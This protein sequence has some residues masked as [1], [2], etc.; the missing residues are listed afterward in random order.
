[1]DP[2][3]DRALRGALA[4]IPRY[5]GTARSA[6]PLST[7]ALPAAIRAPPR[8]H[9][10]R[11]R[12]R[13]APSLVPHPRGHPRPRRRPG[14]DPR[15]RL[16]RRPGQ[17]ARPRGRP[18]PATS[19]N[20]RPARN[21]MSASSASEPEK[22][23][24]PSAEAIE[25][26]AMT[27]LHALA[28]RRARRRGRR[29]T[30]SSGAWSVDEPRGLLGAR[31]GTTSTSRPSG[32]HGPVLRRARDARAPAGS[33]APSS[34]T[35]STSSAART[36]TRSRSCHASELRELER[37]PTWGELREQVAA[38]AEGLRALGVERGDRVVAYLPNAPRGADRL[39][40]HRQPRRDLVELLAG[41]RPRQ[42]RR[43]L[44]P[45]RA[46]G[47]VRRRR[48][49]LRRQGLRPPRHGRRAS[50]PRSRAWSGSSSSPT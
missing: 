9:D 10:H 31:S 41:L 29:T 17:A 48:L 42:R 30:T 3:A 38:V 43:P 7:D 1:M 2:D 25:R 24:E 27:A 32:E 19:S 40:R 18:L 12:R 47:A 14:A 8:D 15:H 49:P 11:P 4:P 36:T 6:P 33:R 22:L 39:P 16:R 37:D 45:D 21:R 13:P 50:P 5:R 35:P 44:R 23:W 26:S 46:Q 34:T 28:R 20:P